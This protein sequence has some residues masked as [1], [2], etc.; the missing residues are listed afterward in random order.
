[1]ARRDANEKVSESL[2]EFTIYPSWTKPSQ[3][4]EKHFK[5]IVDQRLL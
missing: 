3:E 2:S 5:V 4:I 1:M